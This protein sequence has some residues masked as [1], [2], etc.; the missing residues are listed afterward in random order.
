MKRSKEAYAAYLQSEHWKA[1][2]ELK[3]EEGGQM[4]H[5]CGK[6]DSLQ[7]HH[8]NYRN[9]IDCE[10]EDLLVL[11]A[12]CHKQLHDVLKRNNLRPGQCSLQG[13]I[14]M[15][16]PDD[17]EYSFADMFADWEREASKLPMPLTYPSEAEFVE[18]AK[19]LHPAPEDINW[20]LTYRV[21]MQQRWHVTMPGMVKVR[22]TDWKEWLIQHHQY[23]LDS[24]ARRKQRLRRD[25][26][27]ALELRNEVRLKGRKIATFNSQLPSN[28]A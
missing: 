25:L 4:C 16:Q 8:I 27:A 19:S 17:G 2:R 26:L 13:T 7:V 24:Q 14:W 5:A 6:S 22:M 20:R 10:L 3:L 23:L 1:L 9:W 11:C 15:A 18:W 28:N 21:R 12:I